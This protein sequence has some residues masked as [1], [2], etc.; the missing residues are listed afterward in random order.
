MTSSRNFHRSS[1]LPEYGIGVFSFFL[2]LVE[3]GS[4][5][6]VDP[7]IAFVVIGSSGS[8]LVSVSVSVTI[9]SSSLNSGEP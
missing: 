1:C 8:V 4:S 6:G 5:L 3:T 2:V 9:S 7:A